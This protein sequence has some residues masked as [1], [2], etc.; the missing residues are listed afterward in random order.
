MN[1]DAN[2]GPIELKWGQLP[3][4]KNH[5]KP[6]HMGTISV[7]FGY[8]LYEVSYCNLCPE[9]AHNLESCPFDATQTPKA[10]KIVALNT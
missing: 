6:G 7:P 8:F 10:C 1:A 2:K 4:W 3:A 9:E 5:L